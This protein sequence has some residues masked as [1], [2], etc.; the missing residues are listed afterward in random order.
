[1]A[2]NICLKV[3]A[4]TTKLVPQFQ[5]P[6]MGSAMK[7]GGALTLAGGC[8]GCELIGNLLLQLN[9]LMGALGLPLCIL[10]CLAS[11]VKF[12]Q[13]VPDSLG[14]PPDP[15]QLV[16]AISDVAVNCQCVVSFALPPPVGVICDFLKMVRDILNI[17]EAFVTCITGLLNHLGTLNIKA[18]LLLARPDPRLRNAG[19][20]L[21]SQVQKLTDALNGKLE[22][23]GTLFGVINPI[24][25]LLAAVT[26]P[27]FQSVMT[28]LQD[29][30]AVFTGSIPI[31]TPPGDFLDAVNT[32]STTLT[33]VTTSFAAIVSVCP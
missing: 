17:L 19:V 32:F 11:V 22:P 23:L 29:G 15:T 7:A 13:A 9:P 31:G 4:P 24:I 12:A 28:D 27:P 21:T 6:L 26:P 14:P 8:N 2:R 1:M 3:C 20:C 5:I 25:T 10:G 33:A 16:Q 18:T 30:F